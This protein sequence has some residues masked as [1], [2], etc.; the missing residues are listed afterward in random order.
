MTASV[1]TT[2]RLAVD[3]LDGLAVADRPKTC[4]MRP[5]PAST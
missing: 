4:P 1:H 5:L 3:L 2:A